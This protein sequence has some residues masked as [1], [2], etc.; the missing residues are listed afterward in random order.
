MSFPRFS[1]TRPPL[2]SM[3]RVKE[4]INLNLSS[5]GKFL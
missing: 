4:Y 1:L 3:N 5:E 2:P